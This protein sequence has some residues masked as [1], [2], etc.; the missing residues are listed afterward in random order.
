MDITVEVYAE[1]VSTG[2][3]RHTHTAHV[4]FVAIDETGKPRRFPGSCRRPPR[5]A[6]ATSAPRRT[7]W[8]SARHERPPGRP[9]SER[10][11]RQDGRALG[12]AR[13]VGEAG[14]VPA[15][16][17]ATSMGAVIAAGLAAGTT[18]DALLDRLVAVGPGGIVREP[19][20]LVFGLFARS[21]LRPAPLRRAIEA[22]VPADA[23]PIS[24]F[25]L[26]VAVVDLD[27]GELLLFGSGGLDA[28]LVDVLCAA[29]ST[30]RPAAPLP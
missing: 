26:T 24:R 25:R 23:S 28:P 5:S 30:K 15:H 9:G 22:L 8:A 13:A 29:R 16:Y 19:L 18:P 27:S 6:S 10:R 20:A 14:L 11:R 21:L 4:V 7:G 1:T 12:A 17:V 3:R 2:E